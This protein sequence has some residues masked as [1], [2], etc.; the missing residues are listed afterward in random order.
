MA[1]LGQAI[2][3]SYNEEAS[4]SNYIGLGWV[5][6][7][8]TVDSILPREDGKKFENSMQHSSN[9]ER[10]FERSVVRLYPELKGLDYTSLPRYRVYWD[11]ESRQ[12]KVIGWEGI[13][14]LESLRSHIIHVYKLSSNTQFYTDSHYNGTQWGPEVGHAL[15]VQKAWK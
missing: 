1:S 2:F 10:M 9:H 3:E 11:E 13:L 5:Y 14:K 7:H 12:S 8:I 15:A 4:A 6:N